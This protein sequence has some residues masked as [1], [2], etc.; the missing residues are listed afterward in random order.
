M[1]LCQ[2]ILT[3]LKS[4]DIIVLSEE[5]YRIAFEWSIGYLYLINYTII[6]RLWYN[7]P[8]CAEFARGKRMC[9]AF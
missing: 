7:L 5:L 6:A 1:I 3:K 8:I 9:K 4:C 2:K